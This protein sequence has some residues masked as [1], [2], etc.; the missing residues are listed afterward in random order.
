MFTFVIHL[1]CKVVG[2]VKHECPCRIRPRRSSLKHF[3]MALIRPGD[4]MQ[5][6]ANVRHIRD[7]HCSLP[8]S[9]R[10]HRYD[11]GETAE[12]NQMYEAC[13]QFK[14]SCRE[15]ESKTDKAMTLM[16]FQGPFASDGSLYT[17]FAH[18]N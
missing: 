13:E 3:C 5:I 9:P 7:E 8:P 16:E 14:A 11:D 12:Q 10:C 2:G 15:K 17:F 1:H 18:H 4:I 6:P